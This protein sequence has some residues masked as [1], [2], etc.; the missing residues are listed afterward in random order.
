MYTSEHP[1]NRTGDGN[2]VCGFRYISGLLGSDAPRLDTPFPGVHRYL[3]VLLLTLYAKEFQPQ[4]SL[5]QN[6]CMPYGFQ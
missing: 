4:C 1:I 6:L 5:V 3:Q 2:P